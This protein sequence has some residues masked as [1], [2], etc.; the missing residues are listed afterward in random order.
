MLVV[1]CFSIEEVIVL[2]AFCLTGRVSDK[3][4]SQDNGD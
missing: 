1:N 3:D 2:I 4:P